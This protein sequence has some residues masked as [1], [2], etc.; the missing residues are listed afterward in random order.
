MLFGEDLI[1]FLFL[2]LQET[3]VIF[4]YGIPRRGN[5]LRSFVFNFATRCDHIGIVVSNTFPQE[6]EI[7]GRRDYTGEDQ[8]DILSLFSPFS[9]F[10][11][12]SMTM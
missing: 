2:F 6:R 7:F 8:S 1:V 10:C 5:I 4:E 9:S 11:F 3:D 12:L